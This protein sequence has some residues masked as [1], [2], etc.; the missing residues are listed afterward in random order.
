[1]EK[2]FQEQEYIL[3]QTNDGRIQIKQLSILENILNHLKTLEKKPLTQLQSK[4]EE[5]LFK[6]ITSNRITSD[7]LSRYTC[8]IYIYLFDKGRSSH[9]ND[10]IN[11]V[12]NLLKQKE[13]KKINNSNII[14]TF[15]WIIGYITK[16]C[17]YKSPTMGSLTDAL[18]ELSNNPEISD[19]FLNKS[20]KLIAKFLNMGNNN[21]FANK[22]PE[23]YKLISKNE[24]YI[25]NKKYLLKCIYGS[26][27]YYENKDLVAINFFHKKYNF[28]MELL[29]N[30]FQLKQESINNLA[31]KTFI[32]LHDKIIFKEETIQEYLN[33]DKSSQGNQKLQK[34]KNTILKSN[35][36]LNFIQVINYFSQIDLMKYFINK[37][38][39]NGS[40][41]ISHLNIII[42]YIKQNKE[43]IN[44]NENIIDEIFE[45]L[46]NSYSLKIYLASCMFIEGLDI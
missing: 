28:L 26:L 6:L 13:V 30:Y 42:H 40:R 2:I 33:H 8:Y 22:I 29:E 34:N 7:I 3:K 17:E 25:S 46:M 19:S 14:F 37:T 43:I 45:L 38:S 24:R 15:L 44:L 39:E 23:I 11:S 31:I 27:L 35:E 36:L 20:I 41:I 10:L 32:F 1:M 18:I 12:I 5:L 16:R 9:L 21:I 4:I